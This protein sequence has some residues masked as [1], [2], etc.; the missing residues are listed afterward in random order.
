MG[1]MPSTST[2]LLTASSLT[3]GGTFTP[4]AS[5]S[6]S[7]SGGGQRVLYVTAGTLSNAGTTG[8]S[9]QSSTSASAT[10][11]AP[12]SGSLTI[13]AIQASGYGS[14]V[15]YQKITVSAAGATPT[16]SP[17]PPPPSPP[18]PALPACPTYGDGWTAK[19]LDASIGYVAHTK[20]VGSTFHLRLEATNAGWLGFGIAELTSGHMKGAD[21]VT[22][23]IVDGQVRV[24]DRH[25]TFAPT[26]YSAASGYVNGYTG[27]T[28]TVDVH[29]D[30]T[31]VA[32]GE[33]DGRMFVWLT[34]PLVTGDQ[35]DR[36]IVS[37][38]NR[39]VWAWHPTDTVAGHTGG[40]AR[41]STTAIFFGSEPA[42]SAFPSYD[43]K[44]TRRFSSYTVPTRV[45]TYACQAFDF[46]TDAERHIVAIRPIGVTKYNHHAILHVCTNNDYHVQHANPQ[47]CSATSANPNP[48]GGQGSSPLGSTTADCSGL[49]W[50]WAVGM[51]DFV[52]PPEAGLR[53][54]ASHI[55]HVVL[56]IHYDNPSLDVGVVDSMGFEAFYINTP[57]ANDAAMMIIGDPIVRLGTTSTAPYE[58]GNLPA[59]QTEVHRQV[60]CPGTCTKDFASTINVFAHFYH[61]H[62]YGQ[63]MYTEKYAATAPPT[64]GGGVSM[65]VV[66]SRIDFWDNGYQQ[67]VTAPYTIAPGET[68]QTHCWFNTASMSSPITFGTPT[69]SEMCQ[70]FIFYYPAQYRGVDSNGNA[71][72]FAMCGLITDGGGAANTLCGSLA[73]T[74][75]GYFITGDQVDKGIGA[76]VDP[77]NFGTANLAALSTT[78][79]GV[80]AFVAG[81]ALPP[82]PAPPPSPTPSPPPVPVS[83]PSPLV[84][85][86]KTKTVYRVKVELVASGTVSDITDEKKKAIRTAFASAAGVPES[87]VA[88]AVT[89]ASVLISV[90]I[91]S[92]TQASADSVKST[93]APKLADSA[94]ATSFL[95]AAAVTVT[96]TPTLAAY[97]E[98]IVDTPLAAPASDKLG[99]HIIHGVLMVLAFGLVMPAGTAFP[100]FLRD[101]L[102]G[103]RWLRWHNGF[104]ST[105]LVLVTSG[106]AVS[107]AMSPLHFSSTHSILGLVVILLSYLQ[108]GLAWFRPHAPHGTGTKAAEPKSGLRMVWEVLHKRLLAV[109]ILALPIVQVFTGVRHPAADTAKLQPLMAG[110]YFGFLALA[111]CFLAG[112]FILKRRAAADA[113]GRE[114]AA[115]YDMGFSNAV[116]GTKANVQMSR[117]A[118]VATAQ[119]S[120][121]EPEI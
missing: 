74:G 118:R 6:L 35:Q 53:T 95:A 109:I 81:P 75:V 79:Q 107:L 105:A 102:P 28:A 50:S 55:S 77:I 78:G 103:K 7:V 51:G 104:Q 12:A 86:A 115:N 33:T 61:M 17:S 108:G 15:P 120:A 43:G 116:D 70:D 69:S 18:P 27:L 101:R 119:Q 24:E 83:P 59:G 91:T 2:S 87:K 32:G 71:E 11:T 66:G 121:E 36:D 10:L 52:I 82:T 99:M 38:V 111:I 14:T 9:Q 114:E 5:I 49:I 94:A 84:P 16:V 80:C 42:S 47:L 56:E 19:V 4:G 110:L 97:A 76:K 72:R 40:G 92:D 26:T 112:A 22:A 13:V 67:T 30:W 54:G 88:V 46:P 58:V 8:C 96:A 90:V 68:L 45:T 73:Q 39:V 106:F 37:G 21:M 113:A 98:T 93:L 48:T 64:A 31:V 65:G 117:A 44:W 34:R 57:R 20:V 1:V 60:T 25:A 23:A 63:K 85:G 29:A 100:F 41:G 62:N 3:D 89:A